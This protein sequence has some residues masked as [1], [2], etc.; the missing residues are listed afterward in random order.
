MQLLGLRH[1][2]ENYKTAKYPPPIAMFLYKLDS[3]WRMTLNKLIEQLHPLER[4]VV[5]VLKKE[6][7]LSAIAKAAKLQEVKAMRALQ[8]LEN[9]GVLKISGVEDRFIELDR[10]GI[11]YLEKEYLKEQ[12]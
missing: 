9:K 4:K 3:F 11:L 6:A 2:G 1:L 10:N 12:H 8:W 5:P 7:E